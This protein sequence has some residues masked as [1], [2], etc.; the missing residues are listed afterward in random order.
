VNPVYLRRA[1]ERVAGSSVRVVTVCGFPL[2]ASHSTLKAP[3]G[4]RDLAT[5]RA[6]VEARADRLGTSSGV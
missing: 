1:A 5:A 3:T 4:I 6:M 2:G